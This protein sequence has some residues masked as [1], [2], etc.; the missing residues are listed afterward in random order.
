[1][2]PPGSPS[3]EGK[4]EGTSEGSFLSDSGRMVAEQRSPFFFSHALGVFFFSCS[5]RQL[6]LQKSRSNFQHC[7]PLVEARRRDRLLGADKGETA[8]NR[9]SFSLFLP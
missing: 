6:T 3:R 5:R 8:G 7:V 4:E 1:M 2:T 9:P